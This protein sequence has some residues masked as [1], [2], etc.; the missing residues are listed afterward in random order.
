MYMYAS[1]KAG[2]LGR[3]S[4]ARNRLQQTS[5]L[6]AQHRTS[7]TEGYMLLLHPITQCSRSEIGSYDLWS[8]PLF[9]SLPFPF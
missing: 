6:L 2:T 7:A 5:S 8:S 3:L 4:A 1:D 9:P